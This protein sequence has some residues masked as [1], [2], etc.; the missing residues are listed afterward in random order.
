MKY[1]LLLILFSFC[2]QKKNQTISAE[3]GA[4]TIVAQ[5][6][7]GIL[8][9]DIRVGNIG[10][11]RGCET[12]MGN[13]AADSFAWKANT[14][15]GLMNGGGIRHDRNVDLISK[16]TVFTRTILDS[17]MPFSNNLNVY[18]LN[19]YRIKQAMEGGVNKLLTSKT[20]SSSDDNDSDGP[21]HGNC[22]GIVGDLEGSG[23]F[24][25]VNSRWKFKINPINV[26]QSIT[27]SASDK[28]LRVLS[29]GRRITEIQFDGNLLYS[30]SSGDPNSGWT[31]GRSSC[32]IKGISFNQSSACNFYSVTI[33]DFYA[34][35]GDENPSFNSELQ[36]IQNDGTAINLGRNAGVDKN[37]ILEYII[38]FS[39]Y[40]PRV[41]GRLN[42]P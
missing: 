15:L 31:S 19:A 42:L 32:T 4:V 10:W 14:Q 35:G 22:Y 11:T 20:F 3:S 30:N 17:F 16:G 23:R 13:L 41:E 12:R 5:A 24:L 18:N 27:G 26:P 39:T 38:N 7:R 33:S 1:I 40:Y 2:I 28:T 36:E 34:S 6:G 9:L 29:E 25:F 21:Q 8:G 37:A